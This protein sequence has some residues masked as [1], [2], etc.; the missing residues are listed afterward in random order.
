VEAAKIFAIRHRM[1]LQALMIYGT[2][3]AMSQ[4]MLDDEEKKPATR[5]ERA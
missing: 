5:K 2:T 3:Y 1:T 4:M